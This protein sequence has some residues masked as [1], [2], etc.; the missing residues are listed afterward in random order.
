MPGSMFSAASSELHRRRR[1]G[2][3]PFFSKASIASRQAIVHAKISKLCRIFEHYHA[4]GEVVQMDAA[5]VCLTVDIIS[6][7]VYGESYDYLG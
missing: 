1:G 4:T 7:L 3:N 2:V 6:L 5:Y